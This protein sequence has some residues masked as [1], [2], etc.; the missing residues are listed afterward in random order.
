MDNDLISR[1]EARNALAL[2]FMP[3]IAKAKTKAAC[4]RAS[5]QLRRGIDAINR[6]PAVNRDDIMPD[7]WWVRDS[8]GVIICSH[9][10][11]PAPVMDAADGTIDRP[12]YCCRCGA[13][14]GHTGE[15]GG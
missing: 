5:R 13:T 6:I 8:G 3:M 9:C 1:T 15:Q 2:S 7:G 11:S 14:M 10:W 12:A 4:D